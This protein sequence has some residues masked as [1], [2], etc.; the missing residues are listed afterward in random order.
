[1]NQFLSTCKTRN[2][3]TTVDLGTFEQ[4]S[5]YTF[6]ATSNPLKLEGKVFLK[7]LLNLTSAE[8]SLNNLPP[9]TSIPFYHKHRLNEEIYIF[10]RGQGEFQVDDCVFSVREGTVVRVDPEGERCLRNIS[11][12]ELLG[13]IVIQSRAN[14]YIGDTIED[15]FGVDKRVSWVGKQKLE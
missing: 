13:W 2:N 15:G 1:M 5:Q 4:L 10:V 8:I 14:S 12:T 11:D 7:E 9:K 6:A 3:F